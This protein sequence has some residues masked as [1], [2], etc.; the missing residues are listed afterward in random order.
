MCLRECVCVY[1]QDLRQSEKVANF[2]NELAK[3]DADKRDEVIVP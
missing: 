1:I 3:P 2:Y